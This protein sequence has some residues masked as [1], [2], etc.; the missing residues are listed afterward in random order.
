MVM[1][2]ARGGRK[3]GPKPKFSKADVVDAAFAVGIADFT[4]A[5]VARQLSVAT[6]AV[7]RI[8]DSRD[9]L[10]HACLSRAAAEI[11]AAFDPD[12]SWQ[13][14]LLLWADRCWSM[15]ERYPGL[16]LTILRHPSA[17][18]HMED[19]LKRFVEFLT[20]AGLPQESAAFAIDF[21]GDTV[22]TTHIGVSAMRN[23]NDSGQR[24]LDTIFART[25][26]DAVFKPDE[27][28]A[29]RGFLDKKLK[30]IITGLANELES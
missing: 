16:S 22:I 5:Q 29:D 6:S 21:I 4:L 17:V 12:L 13:E 27:G 18:I 8:F 23:V 14:A 10:V 11:A 15:Y 19:H 2:A 20:A 24:E 9:E 3:T 7:Y 28:W 1:I 30:F 25:S 26:D